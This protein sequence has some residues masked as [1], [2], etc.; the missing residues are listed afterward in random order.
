MAKRPP[1]ITIGWRE[2]VALPQWGVAG[3]R[4]KVDTG[5]RT[6][7][8]HVGSME[9]LPDGQLRFEVVVREKPTR[10]A[11]WVVATPVREAVIKPS[12]GQAQHRPVFRTLLRVGDTEREIELSLVSRKGMLCRM[13]IGR[14]A[15]RGTFTVDPSRTYLLTDRITGAAKPPKPRPKR[16]DPAPARRRTPP[17]PT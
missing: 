16:T 7:A 15:M 4:A 12:S 1:L 17:Q 2:N 8:I 5:A 14:T 9:K 11:V 3:I 10:E 6:S 13:L